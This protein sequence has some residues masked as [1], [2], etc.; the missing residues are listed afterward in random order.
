MLTLGGLSLDLWRLVGERRELAT[1][2]DAAAVAAANG[3][4]VATFRE[5][6]LVQLD[7]PL[8]IELAE[9]SLASQP[10]GFDVDLEPDWLI[11]EADGLSVVVTLRREVDLTLLRIAG[12]TSV[13]IGASGRATA[14]VRS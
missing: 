6:G 7:P 12:G 4:D 8:V 11:I 9:A 10:T 14:Q 5:S 13:G 1:M 2:A 3:V